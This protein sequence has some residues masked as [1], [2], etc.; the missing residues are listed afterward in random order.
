MQQRVKDEMTKLITKGTAAGL[1][2]ATL[3]DLKDYKDRIM[4][5]SSHYDIEQPLFRNE[6][7]NA[8]ETL[9]KLK[10]E[11]GYLDL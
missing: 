8:I 9:D 3:Q 11:I 5:P 7:K 1:T 10:I 2:A 6:L 4:N